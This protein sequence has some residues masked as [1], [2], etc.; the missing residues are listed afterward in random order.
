MCFLLNMVDIIEN[1]L[2]IIIKVKYDTGNNGI[3][4]KATISNNVC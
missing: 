3:I 2:I 4:K 1:I